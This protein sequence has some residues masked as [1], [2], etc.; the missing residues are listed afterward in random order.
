MFMCDCSGACGFVARVLVGKRSP[1]TA[2]SCGTKTIHKSSC[3]PSSSLARDHHHLALRV[4]ITISTVVVLRRQ[5]L[6]PG[7]MVAGSELQSL[8]ASCCMRIAISQRGCPG[9]EDPTCQALN[10]NS[11][12]VRA[13][14][15]WPG[16]REGSERARPQ[17]RLRHGQGFM[18]RGLG[19]RGMG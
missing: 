14:S 7:I 6:V 17:K 18:L 12:P 10:P 15:L 2:R 13:P 1:I 16:S 3:S 11:Y 8:R 5:P 4:L 9:C 19:V